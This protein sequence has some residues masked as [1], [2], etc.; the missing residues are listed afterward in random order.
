MD[1]LFTKYPQLKNLRSLVPDELI[2]SEIGSRVKEFEGCL[3]EAQKLIPTVNLNRVFPCELEKGSIHLES[4]LGHWGNVSIEELCKIC[5]I[6][7][8]LKPRRILEMGTYNGMTTLQMALNAPRDCITYTLDL[9]PQQAAEIKLGKLDDLVAKHF[10]DKFQTATGSYFDGREDVSIEQLWGNT[11]TF[12]Y[13]K[14]NGP[15]DL[16]FVDAAHDYVNKKIDSEKAF[17]MVSPSGVIIWHDYAQVA[18][19]DVTRCVVEFAKD[20]RI[21]H[22]RNTNLAVFFAGY[23]S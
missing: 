6:V 23:K 10:K 15:I 2:Y 19:P 5:L 20:H 9:D 13:S 11:A 12:D 7:K 17:S 18:N 1:S 4:F 16:V 8:W 14:L 22:L 21:F 3:S